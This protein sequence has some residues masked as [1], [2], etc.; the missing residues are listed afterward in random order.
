MVVSLR[1]CWANQGEGVSFIGPANF[2]SKFSKNLLMDGLGCRTV[3]NFQLRN[4]VAYKIKRNKWMC[5][6]GGKYGAHCGG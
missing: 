1:I 2:S 4:L 6:F 3:I 5:G